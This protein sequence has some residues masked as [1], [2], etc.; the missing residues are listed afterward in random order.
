MANPYTEVSISNYNANPPADDGSETSDN[1]I[2]WAKHKTKLSDPIKTAY[3]ST[4]TNI[5]TA[6]AKV[7]FIDKVSVSGAHTQAAGDR[8]KM[9]DCTNSPTITLLAAA[10]AG[11]GFTFGVINTG[12]GTVTLDGN[13]AETINGSATLTLAPDTGGMFVCDGSNWVGFYTYDLINLG[14]TA[15]V[16]EIN[17]LDVASISG[18]DA[19]V[20]H[21]IYSD[22]PSSTQFDIDANIGATFESVGPTSSGATNIWSV[23]DSVPLGALAVKLKIFTLLTGSTNTD[24]YSVSVYAR[25]TGGAASVATETQIVYERFTNYSGS[26]ES[27]GGVTHVTIPIDASGRFDLAYSTTGTS[28]SVTCHAYVEGFIV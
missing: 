25:K 9:Y 24:L 16:A 10:T 4:Q 23:L 26:N 7:P 22:G 13:G 18:Y 28:P 19:G 15:S 27:T 12:S 8:G 6:F 20:L 21:Y 2:T 5:T 14:I 11:A 17:A 1:Q 3:E